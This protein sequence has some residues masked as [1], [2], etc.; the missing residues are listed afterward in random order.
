MRAVFVAVGCAV[1]GVCRVASGTP[2]ILLVCKAGMEAGDGGEVLAALF[3]IVR[4]NV[5][6]TW[7]L[8]HP[9]AKQSCCAAPSHGSRLSFIFASRARAK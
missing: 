5:L 2:A 3:F 1:F 7:V 9:R 6:S 4:A 8:Y